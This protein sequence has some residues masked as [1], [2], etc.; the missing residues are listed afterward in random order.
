M[1]L[2]D[3]VRQ[4]WRWF[5][6]QALAALTLIPVIWVALP[7]ESQALVPEEYRPWVLAV[8]ALAGLAGRLV[9]QGD[10]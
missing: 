8:V 5:S 7:P 3:D 9:K 10:D 4:A 1:R 2:V 6:V